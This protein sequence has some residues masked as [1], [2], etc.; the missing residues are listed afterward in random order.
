MNRET[1][2]YEMVD[3][4]WSTFKRQQYW[5]VLEEMG[6]V[7]ENEFFTFWDNLQIPEEDR[8]EESATMARFL[9]HF[10]RPDEIP[11]VDDMEELLDGLVKEVLKPEDDGYPSWVEDCWSF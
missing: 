9:M 11:S 8:I 2:F 7:S 4:N 1:Y 6:G 5:D 3:L 10:Y